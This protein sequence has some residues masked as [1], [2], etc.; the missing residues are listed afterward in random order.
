MI[1]VILFDLDGTLCDCAELHYVSL[2]QALQEVSGF[3]INREDHEKNYNG[4]PTNKKL[5]TLIKLNLIREEDKKK[6]WELKQKYTKEL[7]SKILTI[8]PIKIE[9][10]NYIKYK[11]IK[12]ACVTNSIRET[13]KLILEAT[14]QY[15]YMD[16]LIAN[17]MIKYPKPHAEGYI[18]AM[19]HFNYMPD[20]VLIVEDAP[21]GI[22]AAKATAANVWELNNY[23]EL[24]IEN[25]KKYLEKN[26]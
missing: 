7:I 21:V 4:L 1:E 22:Q 3:I 25:M 16:L 18:R 17:D 10:L 8:D 5:E 6:I 2:N 11:N 23:Q 14:D 12:M 9:L 15:K 19:I 24:N 20:K 26:D 13:A